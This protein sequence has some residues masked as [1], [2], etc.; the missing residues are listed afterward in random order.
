MVETIANQTIFP[1]PQ[2]SSLPLPNVCGLM[3]PQ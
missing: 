1:K 2:G 3:A